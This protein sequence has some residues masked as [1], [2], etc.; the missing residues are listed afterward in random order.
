MASRVKLSK[1]RQTKGKAKAANRFI[2]APPERFMR[3]VK[4]E[5]APRLFEWLVDR[6]YVQPVTTYRSKAGSRRARRG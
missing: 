1:A 2:K 3:R 4:P 6:G 5:S